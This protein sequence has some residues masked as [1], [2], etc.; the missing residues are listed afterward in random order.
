MQM[1]QIFLKIGQNTLTLLAVNVSGAIFG[2]ALAAVLGRGLGDAGFGRY[3][4]VMSWLLTLLVFSEFGLST[5][6]TRDLAMNPASTPDYLINSIAAKLILALP[7]IGL[8]LF[9]A[10]QLAPQQN[11]EI[12]AAL[13]WGVIFLVAGLATSSFTGV[14]KARQTM[15]PILWITLAGQAMLLG[16]TLVLIWQQASLAALIGWAGLSQVVQFALAYLIFIR[17]Y[18]LP[19]PTSSISNSFIKILL[20]IA[21]P[22]AVAGILAA[23][24]MRANMLLLAYLQGDQALGWYAA[25]NRFAE[26]GR[27]L[28]GAFFTAVLPAMAALSVTR[29]T[30][31]ILQH[32]L[33]RAQWGLLAFGAAALAGSLLLGGPLIRLTY[34]A[35]YQPAVP[36]LQLLAAALVPALQNSLFIIYLYV[37]GDEKFVNG[38]LATGIVINLGLCLWFIPAW[39]ATGAAVALLFSE[40]MVYLLA[41]LRVARFKQLNEKGQ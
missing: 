25:A 36:I 19:S 33:H 27:Q 8:L 12:S 39:G 29:H 18:S 32:T 1:K 24:Q 41:R 21:W 28:P 30:T 2:F 3:T 5:V 13:R 31:P 38:L 35:G 37:Q 9:F 4:F 14:F 7:G 11:P 15:A 34:G 23:L 10:P 26:A 22:F 16:G 6:L 40:G 17:Q 20:K